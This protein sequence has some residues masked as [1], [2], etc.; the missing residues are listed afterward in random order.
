[1]RLFKLANRSIILLLNHNQNVYADNGNNFYKCID[2]NILKSAE[3]NREFN[4]KNLSSIVI[5][6]KK[7]YI[8]PAEYFRL[9]LL[10]K[11]K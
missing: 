4:W 9:L 10:E 1:M 3:I 6:G 8:Y 7:D 11:Y 2:K 5:N